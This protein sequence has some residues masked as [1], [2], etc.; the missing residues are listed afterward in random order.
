MHEN[1]ITASGHELAGS[2]IDAAETSGMFH[3]D[4]LCFQEFLFA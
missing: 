2:E 3:S 1:F 4:V